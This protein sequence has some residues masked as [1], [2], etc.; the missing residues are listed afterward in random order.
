M[1][2]QATAKSTARGLSL[3]G[4]MVRSHPG[5]PHRAAPTRFQCGGRPLLWRR[6]RNCDD[7]L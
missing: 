2:E 5:R 3:G 7:V 4:E 1:V 6:A